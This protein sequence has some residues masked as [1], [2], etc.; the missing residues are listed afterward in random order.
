[1]TIYIIH[2]YVTI[3]EKESINLRKNNEGYMGWIRGRKK[4]IIQL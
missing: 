3:T 1:M 4:E 2:I